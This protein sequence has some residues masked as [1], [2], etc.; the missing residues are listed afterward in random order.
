MEFKKLS[1]VEVV[2]EPTEFANVLI[3]ENGVIKKAPKTAVGG[4][5][6]STDN[7]NAYVIGYAPYPGKF[8]PSTTQDL[9]SK[10]NQVFTASDFC[11][12]T[13]YI[14]ATDSAN[15]DPITM[16]Y[17]YPMEEIYYIDGDNYF[18][19]RFGANSQDN[20]KYTASIYSN[21]SINIT[22]S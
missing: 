13:L 11:D 10:I 15:V 22:E 19:V 8:L 2:A 3:E 1:D 18:T 6:V 4:N 7:N 21:G 17:K 5:N 16:I 20:S 12:V 14:Y 9:Y